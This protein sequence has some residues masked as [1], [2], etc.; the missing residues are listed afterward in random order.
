MFFG[1]VKQDCEIK[2]QTRNCYF[3]TSNKYFSKY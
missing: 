3:S 2:K 1:S